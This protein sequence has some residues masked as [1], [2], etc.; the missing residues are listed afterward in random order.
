MGGYGRL[1]R[2]MASVL[3]TRI[4]MKLHDK[5]F[6]NVQLLVMLKHL[7]KYRT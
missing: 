6:F 1:G 7:T 5:S 3:E 2:F 4:Q